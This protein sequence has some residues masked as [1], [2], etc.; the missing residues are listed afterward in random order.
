M[1]TLEELISVTAKQISMGLLL[2]G[3]LTETYVNSFIFKTHNESQPQ[4]G[5]R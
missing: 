5:K 4:V 2:A 3:I 1:V